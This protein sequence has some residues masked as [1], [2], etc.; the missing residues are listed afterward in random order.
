[1]RISAEP[2]ETAMHLYNDM[3]TKSVHIG[4]L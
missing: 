3:R 2:V 1:L 4:N